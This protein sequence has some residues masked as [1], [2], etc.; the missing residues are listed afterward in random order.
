MIF[1]H[2]I[3]GKVYGKFLEVNDKI[4]TT[5]GYT[6]KE[7][8]SM[9]IRDIEVPEQNERIPA[10]LTDLFTNHYVTFEAEYVTKDRH[11]V[12]VEISA[13]L[14]DLRGR[15]TVLAIVRDI[16]ERKRADDL[17]ERLI[18]ELSQKNA[19]LNRFTYTVSHDLKS[20]LISIR[21][22]L[23][24]LEQ[25]IQKNDAAQVLADLT[26]ISSAAETM[27][28][29]ITTLLELSRSG[30]SVDTPVRIPLT[31]LAGEAAG[32][33]DASLRERGVALVI[34]D[35]LPVVSGDQQRLL[36]VMTN[37][38]D[39]AVKFM[40]DQKEPL[41]ETGVRDDAGTPVF[42]VRDNGMGIKK[43]NLSKLFGLFERFNPDVPGTGIGLATVKRIIE[44]HGGKYGWSRNARGNE[45]R[46]AS[47]CRG[48]TRPRHMGTLCYHR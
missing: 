46:S 15:P 37:L 4:C 14:F 38:L 45:R 32:L 42:F 8:L 16:T 43:E 7:L 40:G 17:R 11:R 25:D 23:G 24:L 20:P 35:N 22:F 10:I 36:Q 34:P 2:E 31:D 30:R 9:N 1:V 33:L 3:T 26:H 21:G 5:L 6:R 41:V 12:P 13:A 28:R 18:H 39:N 27:E 44:A 47:R 19:E 48:M 29:L